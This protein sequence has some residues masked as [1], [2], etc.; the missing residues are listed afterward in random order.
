M[1]SGDSAQRVVAVMQ[2][3]TIVYKLGGVACERRS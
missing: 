2:C 3:L 1:A